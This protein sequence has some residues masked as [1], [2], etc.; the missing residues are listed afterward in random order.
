MGARGKNLTE[1]KDALFKEVMILG[2]IGLFV[3]VITK[4][5]VLE[6]ISEIVLGEV[7]GENPIAE[8][9]EQVSAHQDKLNEEQQQ[10]QQQQ[11]QQH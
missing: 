9:F 8:S 2:F 10:Q 5:G 7:E 3:F 4:S 6:V 1:M 11:Q